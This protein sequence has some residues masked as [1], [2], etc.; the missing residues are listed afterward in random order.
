VLLTCDIDC[1]YTASIGART[2]KGTAIGGSKTTLD[3]GGRVTKGTKT[4]RVSLVAPVNPAP[5]L[6]RTRV[7]RV[8]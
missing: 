3:F 7:V 6:I 2:I 4:L 8:P 5:A 1:A